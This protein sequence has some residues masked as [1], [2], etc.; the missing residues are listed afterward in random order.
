MGL[1]GAHG[2]EKQ[3]SLIKQFLVKKWKTEANAIVDEEMHKPYHK[4]ACGQCKW[5][6]SHGRRRGSAGT[7]VS[8]YSA[9]AD[10]CWEE[11]GHDPDFHDAS[12]WCDSSGRRRGSAGFRA[13]LV[14]NEY[15]ERRCIGSQGILAN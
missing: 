6:D 8:D 4:R 2:A 10:G 5:C 13:C 7:W 11:P 14:K 3:A 9:C 12:V 15:S 1:D